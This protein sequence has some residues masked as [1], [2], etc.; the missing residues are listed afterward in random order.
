MKPHAA[1]L[2]VAALASSATGAA[3]PSTTPEPP[4]NWFEVEVLVFRHTVTGAANTES[5]PAL[6][7]RPA[8]DGV[9]EPGPVAPLALPFN[10]LPTGSSRLTAQWDALR[11]S[12]RYQT[13][14]YFSWLQPPLERA[15][16]LPVRLASPEVDVAPLPP[17]D[18]AAVLD[19]TAPPAAAVP[20]GPVLPPLRTPLDG[21]ATLSVQR[22]LYLALDL[23]F[24][25]PEAALAPD[26][27]PFGGWRLTEVR[28]MR[29]KELHYFDH[30]AFG[31]LA[32]VTPRPAPPEPTPGT[33]GAAR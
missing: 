27:Q 1:L 30:P 23:V 24:L 16:A 4:E 22:Y 11:R 2:C 7:G 19:G 33:T 17:I 15:L 5:W 21:T 26:G 10:A 3:V 13:I 12:S 29:S 25:P 31:A 8:V 28:R 32:L 14:A 6:P 18:A 20:E 9:A